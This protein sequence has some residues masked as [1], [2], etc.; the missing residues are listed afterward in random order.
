MQVA[1]NA[2]CIACSCG[3]SL[4]CSQE[5]DQMEALAHAESCALIKRD[6]SLRCRLGTAQRGG[7]RESENRMGS[8]L[9][10]RLPNRLSPSANTL[11]EW[12]TTKRSAHLS[13]LALRLEV[14]CGV[15]D[16]LKWHDHHTSAIVLWG[17]PG[18]H[19]HELLFA[20]VSSPTYR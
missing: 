15:T 7:M 14:A 5:W 12:C 3:R 4:R 6:G 13:R 2:E 20:P 1:E 8:T 10:T 18:T 17:A 11:P 19:W 9:R 16:E